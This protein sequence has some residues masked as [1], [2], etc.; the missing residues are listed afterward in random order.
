MSAPGFGSPPAQVIATPGGE[1]PVELYARHMAINELVLDDEPCLR[2]LVGQLSREMRSQAELEGLEVLSI[3]TSITG[4]SFLEAG[5][6]LPRP[7][8]HRLIPRRWRP[9]ARYAK[10]PHHLI[11]EAR[12]VR[13]HRW[14]TQLVWDDIA[15]YA[16]LSLA[17]ATHRHIACNGGVFGAL[18]DA[19]GIAQVD[20]QGCSKWLWTREAG[21]LRA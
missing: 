13:V 2:S 4:P 15:R 14:P 3:T 9:A 5:W 7:W 12:V 21:N 16:P 18:V 17:E 1:L 8:W 10:P 20:C 19:G 6:E 11:A